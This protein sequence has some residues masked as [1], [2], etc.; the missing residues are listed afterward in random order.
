MHPGVF[1]PLALG[2]IA[3]IVWLVRLEGKGNAID[4]H[5]AKF[6]EQTVADLKEVES[7]LKDTRTRFFEHAA[8]SAVHHNAEAYIEF[9]NA[10]DRRLT[11][12]EGS[13]KDIGVKLDRIADKK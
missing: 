11:G 1:V 4:A 10:L 9:K 12:F 3:F 13:L 6:K 7:D 5:L 8:D 2:L